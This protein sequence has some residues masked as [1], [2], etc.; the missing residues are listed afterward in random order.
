MAAAIDRGAQTEPIAHGPK[1][2]PQVREVVLVRLP[3][4]N[5]AQVLAEGGE[6]RHERGMRRPDELARNEV[7]LDLLELEAGDPLLAGPERVPDP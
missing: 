7:T 4:A 3:R 2:R 5:R 6:E 1:E